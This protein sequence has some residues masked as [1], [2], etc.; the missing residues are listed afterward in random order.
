MSQ[1]LDSLLTEIGDP[2]REDLLQVAVPSVQARIRE[3][4]TPQQ[5]ELR[6]EITEIRRRLAPATPA[7][8]SHQIIFQYLWHLN[9][10][11]ADLTEE[12][13]ALHDKIRRDYAERNGDWYAAGTWLTPEEA[14]ER[15]EQ[16]AAELRRETNV[17]AS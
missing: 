4:T 2:D 17:D 9:H 3:L 10:V 16:R 8:F 5:L 15:I 13:R 12:Q 7:W 1:L 11:D 6:D 14:A